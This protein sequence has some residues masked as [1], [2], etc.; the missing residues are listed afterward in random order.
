ME[1]SFE[2]VNNILPDQAKEKRKKKSYS[3]CE[4]MRDQEERRKRRF[5]LENASEKIL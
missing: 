4:Q 5:F 2:N 3:G 1:G